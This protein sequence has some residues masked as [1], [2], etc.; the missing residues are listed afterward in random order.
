MDVAAVFVAALRI[1]AICASEGWHS[2][3][4]ANPKSLVI[5][6]DLH[7]AVMRP[8]DI[9]NMHSAGHKIATI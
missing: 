1:A 2:L 6:V 5:L 7:Q 9:G 3:V 8:A 4:A